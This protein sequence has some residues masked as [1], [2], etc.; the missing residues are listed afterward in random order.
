MLLY[1]RVG[2]VVAEEIGKV[3]TRYYNVMGTQYSFIHKT[4]IIRVPIKVPNHWLKFP[5]LNLMTDLISTIYPDIIRIP[6]AQFL[7]EIG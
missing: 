4:N 7:N 3:Y 1:A 6:E 2:I 5:R